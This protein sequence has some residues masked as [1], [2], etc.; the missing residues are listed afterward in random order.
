MRELSSVRVVLA[1]TGAS[2]SCYADAVLRRLLRAE[3]AVYLITSATAEKVIRTE[4]AGSLLAHLVT[5]E[6]LSGYANDEQLCRIAEESGLTGPMLSQIKRFR[7]DD[8]YAPVA[9]GSLG[10]THM[11][12]V[13]GSMGALGR[14][15]HG[16]SSN[17]LERTADVMLKERRPLVLVP[18]ETPL[19]L[20]HLRNMTL[21]AEAG[22]HLVPA[23]P[24]FYMN[25]RS[26]DDLVS[27]L[28]ERICQALA[29]P[30]LVQSNAL[31]WNPAR[32]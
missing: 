10:A 11:C 30:E 29:V 8:L 2:G 16:V 31:H 19:N 32:L 9:S 3:C 6:R 1:V 28:C 4:I 14:I 7:N 27:F 23:M 26:I 18:R 17:L 22:A 25:P 15:A 12:V 20:I 13:P 24:A 21:L 5:A